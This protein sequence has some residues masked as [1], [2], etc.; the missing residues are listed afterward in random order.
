MKKEKMKYFALAIVLFIAGFLMFAAFTFS[1]GGWT[2]VLSAIFI[3]GAVACMV[4]AFSVGA[5]PVQPPQKPGERK[6]NS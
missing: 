4:R 5:K 3:F 6:R 2:G 1:F